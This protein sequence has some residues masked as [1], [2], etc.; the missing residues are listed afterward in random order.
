MEVSA[1]IDKNINESMIA[2]I[3]KMLQLGIGLKKEEKK[4]K[5]IKKRRKN[6]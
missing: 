3:D 6:F 5:N 2:L 4:D 1:K